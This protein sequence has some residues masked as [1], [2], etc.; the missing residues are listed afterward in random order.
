MLFRSSRFYYENGFLVVSAV[1]SQ[2]E[3]RQAIEEI[4][5]YGLQGTTEEFWEAPFARRL[6][7]NAKLLSA[8][9]AIFGEDANW[10]RIA[11]ALGASAA[12]FNP[13]K[14]CIELGNLFLMKNGA[15]VSFDELAARKLLQQQ[16]V[17][18]KADLGSGSAYAV[19]WGCDLT[20]DYVKINAS[21]RS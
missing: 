1:I 18:I 13:E 4:K 7:T 15:P 17:V 19:A 12:L 9:T 14:L 5:K 6:V 8:L 20:G 11:S 16:T 21:Y 2:E 3:V 10:G